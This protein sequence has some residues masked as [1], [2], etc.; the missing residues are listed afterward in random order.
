MYRVYIKYC[1]F[2]KFSK[3]CH[4]S[5]TSARLLL[6]VQIIISQYTIFPEH[7]VVKCFKLQ[8]KNVRT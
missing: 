4:L 3:V 6:V 2:S 5:L 7:P 1:V 8:T